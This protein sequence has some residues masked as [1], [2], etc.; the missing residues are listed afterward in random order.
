MR[1]RITG[2][3]SL[4]LEG[5]QFKTIS[6]KYRRGVVRVL[7]KCARLFADM[8][9]PGQEDE[10]HE[11]YRAEFGGRRDVGSEKSTSKVDRTFD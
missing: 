7:D 6:R 2:F 10:V 9:V 3:P 5:V 1:R 11:Q 8:L 4:R